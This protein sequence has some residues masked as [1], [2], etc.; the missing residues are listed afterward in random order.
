[1]VE[2]TEPVQDRR[3]R[4]RNG[5]SEIADV[6]YD[7]F[8]SAAVGGAT[9]GLFFLLV[10]S[11]D[12]RP[13]FTPSLMGTVLFLGSQADTVTQVRLD[14]VA[15]FTMI[16]FAMFGWLGL[17][18][19]LL[20]HQVE[21]HSR[22]PREVIVTLFLVLEGGFLI[23]ANLFMP[24]VTAAIGFGRIVVGNLLTASAMALFMMRS[25][26]PEA[27]DRLIHGKPFI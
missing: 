1:V 9:L 20:V 11:F 10:D 2:A 3:T 22:H 13:F 21:V 5:A 6:L 8:Y 14:M 12:G 24:G 7:A 25:H 18:L 26:N 27:W 17:A 4:E 16:H 23:A 19:S 15:Y